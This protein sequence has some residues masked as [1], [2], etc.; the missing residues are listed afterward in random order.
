MTYSTTVV[1]NGSEYKIEWE[2]RS[3][4][5][6][7]QAPEPVQDVFRGWEFDEKNYTTTHFGNLELFPEEMEELVNKQF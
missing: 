7:V 2:R 6:Y 4:G 5:W 1:H 3:D